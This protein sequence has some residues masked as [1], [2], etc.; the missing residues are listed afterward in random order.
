MVVLS[1]TI[2]ISPTVPSPAARVTEAEVV[3]WSQVLA[4]SA[5]VVGQPEDGCQCDADSTW[6]KCLGDG[7]AGKNGQR[8]FRVL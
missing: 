8:Q 2:P 7:R 1:F 3:P 5:A 6:L 4:F